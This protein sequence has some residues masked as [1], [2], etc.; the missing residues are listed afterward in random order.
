LGLALILAYL[1]N[2][3]VRGA[4]LFRTV[5]FL[6]VVITGA[7]VAL[8]WGWLFNSR[9]GLINQLLALVGIHGPAWLQDAHWA[10]PAM[11]LMSLWNIGGSMIVYLAALQDLPSELVEAAVLN[12][13]NPVQ[14]ARFVILPYI[15]PVTFYLVVLGVIGSF[16]VFTPTYMLTQG[17]PA[18]AT[19][20]AGLYIY[21][22]AFQWH[23][24]GY[25]SVLSW[26]LCV[27]V[28]AVAAVQFGLARRW[29]YYAQD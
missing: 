19:M 17:G 3:R 4:T 21:F 18:N 1:L 14:V 22:N 2:N 15:S 6:P 5:F 7:A 28:V 9:Y 8:L 27:I 25:A 16:Q 23:N 20:T 12:G 26:L 10:M 11:I 29:V 24:I 13:A